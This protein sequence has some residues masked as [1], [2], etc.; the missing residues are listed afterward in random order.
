MHNWATREVFYTNYYEWTVNYQKRWNTERRIERIW[1][2]WTQWNHLTHLTHLTQFRIVSGIC[3]GMGRVGHFL[4]F[5]FFRFEGLQ[6]L[7]VK[8]VL[9][10]KRIKARCLMFDCG[11]IG[12][13]G[14]QIINSSN[15]FYAHTSNIS[16]RWGVD[17]LKKLH[18]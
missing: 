3:F 16:C 2:R 18:L 15:S 13:A 17:N 9:D 12:S 11:L 6:S 4:F 14:L 7:W 1:Q 5:L 10:V 8:F